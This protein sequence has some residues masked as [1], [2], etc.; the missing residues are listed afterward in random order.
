MTTIHQASEVHEVFVGDT[1]PPLEFL[2]RLSDGVTPK[3]LTDHCAFVSFAYA[4][5]T[6]HV[7]RGAAI[8]SF[9][10]G[11]VRYLLEGDEY[12][13]IGR[14]YIRATIKSVNF[15]TYLSVGWNE[16]S[17]ERILERIVVAKPI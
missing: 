16:E 4:G 13:N 5:A 6:P 15:G 7:V 14:V 2:F 11:A 10:N 12:P 1:G 8:T 9:A 3:N 17:A